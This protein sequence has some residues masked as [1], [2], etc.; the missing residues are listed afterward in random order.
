[1]THI[2]R[3]PLCFSCSPIRFLFQ[4]SRQVYDLRNPITKISLIL[5]PTRQPKG[6]R[7]RKV[8]VPE[9]SGKIE[10]RR[11]YAGAAP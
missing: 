10:G 2:L 4:S 5:F 9:I 1:M 6:S 7:S 8:D 3:F 11:P